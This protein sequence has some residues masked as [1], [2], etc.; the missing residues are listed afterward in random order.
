MKERVRAVLLS[1]NDTLLVIKRARQ[2]VAPYCVIVG[3]GVEVSDASRED[4]L[5]RE[6][7]EEV[8]GEAR[9]VRLLHQL[10]NSK[11]ETELFYLARIDRWSFEDR[12][13]PEFTRTDR[14]EYLLEE[15]PLTVEALDSINLMP[16]EFASVLREAVRRG[17][18]QSPQ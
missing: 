1:G 3:G 10:E 15:I 14:G 4:A 8:A 13:G 17:D 16:P 5:L 18:L 11:G 2:G 6:V 7:R 9:I 12:S